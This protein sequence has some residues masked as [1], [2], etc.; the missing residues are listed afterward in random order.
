MGVQ[1]FSVFHFIL[2]LSGQVNESR[3]MSSA[4]T[5]IPA[6]ADL[7]WTILDASVNNTSGLVTKS[8]LD[9]QRLAACGKVLMNPDPS[10]QEKMSLREVVS[11]SMVSAR[12]N[13]IIKSNGVVR[14]G[15][16]FSFEG[17]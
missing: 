3:H 8:L 7:T 4:R 9:V 1:S 15:Y 14:R 16:R 13:M 11:C 6:S 12:V 17:R 2:S 10:N 5:P